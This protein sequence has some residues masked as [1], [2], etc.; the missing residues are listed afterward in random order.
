[1]PL[2]KV[3]QEARIINVS[4]DMHYKVVDKEVKEG[5]YDAKGIWDFGCKQKNYNN[6]EQYA[7]SK[8]LNVIF[9]LQL[10]KK[11]QLYSKC[12]KT[13]SIHPGFV[14]TNFGS[15]SPFVQ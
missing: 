8:L 1:L 13:I 9:T 4:S 14:D 7:V 2:L 3:S 6:L 11:L 12:I 15:S 5:E 10:S